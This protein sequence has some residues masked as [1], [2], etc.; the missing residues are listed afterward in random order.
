M[1]II[2]RF[3]VEQNE[4]YYKAMLSRDYRFDGKFY[5]AVK[6]TGI[7]CRPICPAKP[8]LENIVFFNDSFSAEKAGY[9]PCLRCHPEF[10]PDYPV[11][12][13]KSPIVQKALLLISQNGMFETD[14]ETF[15]EQLNVSSRHLR[16]LFEDEVGL[17]PKQISDLHRLNFA[18]KLIKETQLKLTEVALTS[19]FNSLRRFNDAFKKRYHY[20]PRFIRKSKSIKSENVFTLHIAYRPPLD[21]NNLLHYFLR[22][23]IPFVEKVSDSTYERVFKE[24]S[25]I[26]V[27]TV[28]NDESKAQLTIKVFCQDPKVLFP[29][30]NRIRKMFDINS[31]P[32]LIGNQFSLFPFLQKLWEEFPGLRI[33]RG[34]DPFEIAVGTILGQVISVKQ[35][36]NLMGQLVENYGEVI[37]HPLT[38]EKTFLFPTPEVLSKASLEEIKTTSQRKDAIR[39]LSQAI[40]NKEISFGEYQNPNDFKQHLKKIKGIGSWSAEYISLRG[41]G[42]TNAFPKDDL[43]LN[44]ALKSIGHHFNSDQIAPWQGYLAI[45]LWKKYVKKEEKT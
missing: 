39:Q 28:E 22:H 8:K 38:N 3:P 21:W 1:V 40:F 9:R 37:H 17:S 33:A 45:Y 35:A 5:V 43:V 24:K 32:L 18:Y 13:G 25:S 12:P 34:W 42:D 29:V 16:R 30:V 27:F 44:K 41:L 15:A 7:Y 4:I 26:G 23:Q 11:W 36:S 19:G 6:T 2:W 14:M 20:P 10:S 31:D